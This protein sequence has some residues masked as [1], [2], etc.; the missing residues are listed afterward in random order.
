MTIYIV[1]FGKN[2]KTIFFANETIGSWTWRQ[3]PPPHATKYI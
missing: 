3:P 2:G 1:E